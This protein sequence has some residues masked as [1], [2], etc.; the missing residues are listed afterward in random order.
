MYASSATIRLRQAAYRDQSVDTGDCRGHEE[1]Q[2]IVDEG[3]DAGDRRPGHEADAEGRP[4]QAEA[5]ELS[6]QEGDDA[7][8]KRR[9]IAPNLHANRGLQGII[10]RRLWH[11][12]R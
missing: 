2:S 7:P 11:Q 3:S 8:A 12:D 6:D 4:Q 10:S 5:G 1:R 9:P